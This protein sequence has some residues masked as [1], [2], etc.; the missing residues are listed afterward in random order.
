MVHFV[1]C[2]EQTIKSYD[3]IEKKI[4]DEFSNFI[5]DGME[6]EDWLID[7]RDRYLTLIIKIN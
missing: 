5:W 6:A 4:E 1:S 2:Y 3:D 7:G